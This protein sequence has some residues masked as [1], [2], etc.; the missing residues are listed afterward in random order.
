MIYRKGQ[1]VP[2]RFVR[3]KSRKTQYTVKF[4]ADVEINGRTIRMLSD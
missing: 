2:R 3:C 1:I 4:G